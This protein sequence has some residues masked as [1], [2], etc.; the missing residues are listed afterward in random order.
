LDPE[1]NRVVV[2][3]ED[4][5]YSDQMWVS[6]V[7]YTLGPSPVEPVDVGVK[8]RYKSEEAAARLYPRED[9]ALVRFEQPQRAVTPGQAA[10]FYQGE[11]LLGGG[12]IEADIPKDAVL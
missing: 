6:R 9:G 12:I 4:A 11:V 7:N 3:P 10:V 2:G 1:T 5:L 8:I